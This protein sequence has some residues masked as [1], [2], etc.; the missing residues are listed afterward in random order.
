MVGRSVRPPSPKRAPPAAE[1][2]DEVEEI[3]R[4][5]SRPQAVRILRKRGDEVVVMEDDTTREVKRLQSAVSTVMKQI[6]VSIVS[7]M[8]V[9]GVEEC[10]S[11]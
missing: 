5:E 4:E 2:E 6:E 10:S 8:Y 7:A 3:E 1:D 11:S 9:F